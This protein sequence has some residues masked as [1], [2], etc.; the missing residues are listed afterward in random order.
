[1][2]INSNAKSKKR[3]ARSITNQEEIDKILSLSPYDCA[4][5]STLMDLFADFG[6]G[7]KYNPYDIITIPPGSYGKTKK[8]KNAFVTTIGLY[9]YNKGCIED[10]SDVIGY[11]NKTVT[12]GVFE[13]INS[14]LSYALLEDKITVKQLKDFIMQTQIYMSCASAICPSHTMRMI[15]VTNE[16]EKHK[17]QVRKKYAEGL[18]NKDLIAATDMAD[19][20]LEFAKDYMGDDPSTDMYN[21]GARSSWGNNFKNMYVMKGAVKLTDGTYDTIE[22][23]Y[24]DGMNKEEFV[25]A[26]DSAVGGPYSRAVNTAIGGHK[27]KLFI[28]ATQHIK[29]GKPGSD[30]GTKRHINVTITNKN[31]SDWMYSYIIGNNGNLI[32][33]TSDNIDKYINKTVKLRF[34]ALCKNAKNGVICEK[35]ASARF[36]RIGITNIGITSFNAMSALKNASMKKFHDSTLDLHQI[37]PDDFFNLN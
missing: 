9:I 32:E 36:N 7:S 10:V 29:V 21:S 14:K 3:V 31:K 27:E 23:S 30:C 13:D 34:S 24:I 20:M 8:N 33:L 4:K 28:A 18:K 26:N 37:D 6:N 35:C 1:M 11:V 22:S 17:K 19:E 12:D 25:I 2:G 5:K 16:V 15:L